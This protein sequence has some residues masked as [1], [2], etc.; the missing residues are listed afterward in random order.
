MFDNYDYEIHNCILVIIALLTF[1]KRTD[2]SR[3][4]GLD[5]GTNLIGWAIINTNTN[6]IV[7]CGV[8]IYPTTPIETKR[9][10]N[11]TRLVEY[12]T[13]ESIYLKQSVSAKPFLFGLMFIGVFTLILTITNTKIGNFGLIF[14]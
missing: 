1:K 13:T 12:L 4:L 5:S 3:I 8:T 6:S 11:I 10:N 2:M 14:H 7:D 9:D